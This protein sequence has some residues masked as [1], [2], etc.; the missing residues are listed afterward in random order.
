MI[1]K[2]AIVVAVLAIGLV[3]PQVYDALAGSKQ[4]K[5]SD[6]VGKTTIG[7]VSSTS[8]IRLPYLT[9][10]GDMVAFY[11][12]GGKTTKSGS[13]FDNQ[14]LNIK[15]V[16]GDDFKQQVRDY[17]S[18]KS[19]FLRCTFRQCALASEIIGQDSRTKG[20]V[21]LQMTWSAGDH[22]VARK[23]IKDVS[24]LKGK[25]IVLQ[26][27]GPHIGMLDD[28]LST[29][30][31][32]WSDIKVVWADDLTGTK[33]S[34][35]EMFK[36]NKKYDAAF[37]I[38]PDMAGLTGGLDNTG[39]GAEGTV[40]G[41]HV[42]VSTA[43]LSRSIAD[44]YVVR[45]DFYDA[46]EDLVHK[47]VAGYLQ[48]A[49]DVTDLKKKYDKSGSA[50]YKKLLKL[51]MKIYGT[52][53]LPTLVDADGLFS[54]CRLVGYAG[55]MAFFKDTSTLLGFDTFNK[56][57]LA[58]AKSQ[59]FI[60]KKYDFATSPIKWTKVS[61]LGKLRYTSGSLTGRFDKKKTQKE[62]EGMDK[63]KM[64]SRTIYS[65]TINFEANQT[66]FTVTKYKKEFKKVT[67]LAQMYGGAAIVIRGHTDPTMTLRDFV[68]AGIDKGIIKRKGSSGNYTYWYNGRELD[69]NSTE[70]IIKLIESGAFD[71]SSKADPRKTMS[72]ALNLSKKRADKVRK[73]LISY[74]KGAKVTID[75]TQVQSQGVGVREP[76]NPKPKN[77]Y[78]AAENRRVEF[79]IV[80][81]S[82]EATKSGDFD[83]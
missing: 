25:T 7:T 48:A 69:I 45:K 80:R 27:G 67:E 4:K 36:K 41:A 35:G 10:G 56:K 54:D 31:L 82:A 40:K 34:P 55:N 53:T 50:E 13:I 47:F 15:L 62:I 79:R 73:S 51:A 49:E 68:I 32:S 37:V 81:V 26:K 18:G 46:N 33:S 75:D 77:K 3:T 64:D 8:T 17:M 29:A 6:E 20:V 61:K 63:K 60:S 30:G 11:A 83:F 74:A 66:D 28:I 12:N 23:N 59:G 65:F 9:W 42:L 2:L 52:K 76:V 1:R 58:M 43:Q 16:K 38:S 44:V 71:G 19:P 72:V 70:E 21:V 57:S 14:G 78:E 5:F 24:Q 39:S 22:L